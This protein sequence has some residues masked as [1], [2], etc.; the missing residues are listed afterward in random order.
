VNR[1]LAVEHHRV[2][3][4]LSRSD[5]DALA[6]YTPNRPPPGTLGAPL[7]PSDSATQAV[8][9]RRGPSAA[10]VRLRN[11]CVRY[12][13]SAVLSNVSFTLLRGEHWALLGPNGAGKTTLLSLVLADNPQAYANDVEVFG[14]RRGMGESIW[15][16][17]SR[18][19][20]V[21]PEL[22]A[23]MPREIDALDVVASGIAGALQ[24]TTEC[25]PDELEEAA[26]RLRDFVPEAVNRAFGELSFAEQR[27]VL[28]ARALVGAPELLILDEPCHGLDASHRAH[29]IEAVNRAARTGG[30]S[31]IY[32]THQPDEIPECVTHVLE[33]REGRAVRCGPVR[34]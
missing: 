25:S 33:L 9:A 11:V 20:S 7:R 26:A 18:I 30:A 17:K 1:A 14:Q 15:D 4:V 27:L 23:H 5:L 19:G 29:V 6:L 10:L 28:I 12:G 32:V 3:A 34:A 13:E 22:H 31:L 21:S 24:R 8:G 16:I 2:S